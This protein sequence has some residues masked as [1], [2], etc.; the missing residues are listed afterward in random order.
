MK[1]LHCSL[2]AT[3]CNAAHGVVAVCCCC[4]YPALTLLLL[5]YP[6]LC[7][8]CTGPAEAAA[9]KVQ[10]RAAGLPYCQQRVSNAGLPPGLQ[11]WLLLAGQVL[12]PPGV[13]RARL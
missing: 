2:V 13:H 10:A 7:R 1:A 9:F 5:L 11:Q 4:C 6:M 3:Q 8:C 12:L